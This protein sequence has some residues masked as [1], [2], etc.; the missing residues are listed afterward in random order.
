MTILFA[1]DTTILLAGHSTTDISIA[2]TNALDCAY[3]WLWNSG[4]RLNVSKTKS[5]LIH[6]KRQKCLPP[7]NIQLNGTPIEQVQSYKFLG[8]VVNDTLTWD[9]HIQF[10]CTKVSKSLNLLRRL[11]WFLPRRALCCFYSAYVLPHLTYA[12][13]V[14]STCSLGQSSKL[15]RLQNYAARIILKR[16]RDSSA[17]EMRKELGWPTLTSRRTLSETK[18]VFRC[19]TGRSPSYLSAL[20]NPISHTHQHVTRAS[21]T[22]GTSI[23]RIRTEHGRH[24]FAFRGA[25]IW[26]ALPP[27]M[28]ELSSYDAFST[29]VRD[30][31]LSYYM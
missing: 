30:R 28:R 21:S 8:V 25:K 11:A 13:P 5:M 6:S 4:L 1:D 26:N 17:T 20:F 7:M 27:S 19:L 3:K 18:M 2:L 15:E 23:P 14:W 24:S 29:A 31:T 16:R 10:V 22:K 12:D 9:D